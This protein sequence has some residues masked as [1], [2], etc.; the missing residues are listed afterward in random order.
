VF[1]NGVL[2]VLGILI[3]GGI[4]VAA[5]ASPGPAPLAYIPAIVG[6]WVVLGLA[7]MLMLV[8]KPAVV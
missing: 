3:T 8:R 6:V 5:G 2:P 4:V 1:R 7:L